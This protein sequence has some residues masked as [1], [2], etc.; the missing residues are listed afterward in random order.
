MV[1][2]IE[3]NHSNENKHTDQLI[4]WQPKRRIRNDM[5]IK[6]RSHQHDIGRRIPP[7][8][9]FI[10]IVLLYPSCNLYTVQAQEIG[11]DVC[12]CS[13][14]TFQF[15]LDFT[16]TCP[17]TNI[18]RGDAL[19]RTSCIVSPFGAPTTDLSPIVVESISILELDQSNNVIVEVLIDGNLMDGTSFSYTSILADPDD[20][21]SEQQIPKALQMTLNGRNQDGIILLNVF[22]I[23]YTNRCGYFPVVQ[24]GESAGW[25]V[26]TQVENPSF[27][28]CP[29][30]A[31]SVFPSESP[32]Q[33]PTPRPTLNPTRRPTLIP[34]EVEITP[35]P[36]PNPTRRPTPDPTPQPLLAPTDSPT[37]RPTPRPSTF[38]PLT[39]TGTPSTTTTTI[40]PTGFVPPTFSPIPT[41]TF[42]MSMSMSMAVGASISWDVRSLQLL[43][44]E[45][46]FLDEYVD[47]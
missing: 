22:I 17:P 12:G 47:H 25:V 35:D 16:R 10:W 18:T 7:L 44:E 13:P 32:T 9:S 31:P 36:T 39:P 23:T 30:L 29:T 21:T 6:L 1:S 11:V 2:V 24:D 42:D 19:E 27:Q 26:F 8:L 4:E 41:T 45:L 3:N 38:M 33:Q 46:D 14:F 20:I 28:Y 40:G 43:D 5:N 15:N 37:S 34:T